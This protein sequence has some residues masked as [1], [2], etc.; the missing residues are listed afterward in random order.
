MKTNF[1]KISARKTIKCSLESEDIFTVSN[2]ESDH[3]NISYRI[4]F[5][6]KLSEEIIAP[7]SVHQVC[8]FHGYLLG[9]KDLATCECR[10]PRQTINDIAEECLV[11]LHQVQLP[12]IHELENGALEWLSDLKLDL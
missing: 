4:K 3:S 2:C 11:Y 5:S 7:I 6:R 9:F 12:G 8:I 1:K 10:N